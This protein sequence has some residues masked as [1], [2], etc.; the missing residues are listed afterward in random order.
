MEEVVF[1]EH[2]F[3]VRFR[4]PGFLFL[5]FFGTIITS[6]SETPMKFS[7]CLVLLLA[8][9][10]QFQVAGV[11]IWPGKQ[12]LEWAEIESMDRRFVDYTN[13]DAD[14]K[15]A[16]KKVPEGLYKLM[17]GGY[18]SR[19]QQRTI[20]VQP[21]FADARGRVDVRIEFKDSSII[22]DRLKVGV[23][24]LAVSPKA[25]D[26]LHR[27]YDARGDVEKAQQHLQKAIE[28]SPNFEEAL[29][30]LGTYYY[31]DGRFDTA[32]NLFQRA[33]KANP[34][35][36]AAQVNLGG[37]LLS[38]GDYPR[39]L[40]ENLKALGMRSDDA[41]AQAQTGETL[42][43]LMR[44]DEAIMHLE[45]ARQLDPMSFTLPG[46]FIARIR[47][48]Q[49][50]TAGAIAEY[51]EFLKIHPGHPS[52]TFVERQLFELESRSKTSH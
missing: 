7:F 26:E 22:S 18:R 21:A 39:A 41:L 15:F 31:R 8:Q 23:A 19:E 34:N 1:V 44:Y 49:G 50:D 30:N 11:V 4:E 24:E 33:L 5:M 17:V 13:I 45:K 48:V 46:I 42:F 25:V 9:S 27:A 29:N 14:G 3:R 51:K 2:T 32:A 36:F 38:L 52:T 47:A 16:F 28:I 10:R 12:P 6:Q 20:E 35:S 43:Y 37:A 40:D